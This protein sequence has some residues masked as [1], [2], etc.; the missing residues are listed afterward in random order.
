M[1]VSFST[2]CEKEF[3]QELWRRFGGM[4]SGDGDRRE[5]KLFQAQQDDANANAMTK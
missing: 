2:L 4:V 5:E 1:H 3:V